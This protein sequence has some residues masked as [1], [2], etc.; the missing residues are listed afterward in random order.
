MADFLSLMPKIA[1]AAE[2]E[3]HPPTGTGV[4]ASQIRGALESHAAAAADA[5]LLSLTGQTVS[6]G[7]HRRHQQSNRPRAWGDPL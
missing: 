6:K 3:G 1:H 5:R 4:V 7:T 2:A